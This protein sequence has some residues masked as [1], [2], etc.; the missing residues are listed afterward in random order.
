[1]TISTLDQISAYTAQRQN[2][3]IPHTSLSQAIG[4]RSSTLNRSL[5]NASN[6]VHHENNSSTKTSQSFESILQGLML[7]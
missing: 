7:T 5:L 6:K 2:T 3:L 1:M 4:N